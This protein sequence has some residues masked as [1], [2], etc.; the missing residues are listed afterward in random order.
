M[1]DKKKQ[2]AQ[3]T[4]PAMFEGGIPFHQINDYSVA[5]GLAILGHARQS[6]EEALSAFEQLLQL[7]SCLQEVKTSRSE[8]WK[9]IIHF[10]EKYQGFV[11]KIS[12]L[13]L[14]IG[15]GI[16]WGIYQIHEDHPLASEALRTY[17]PQ[18]LA[19][20]NQLYQDRD[21]KEDG[22]I[23]NH[24]PWET[25]HGQ[26]DHWKEML[27]TISPPQ[28]STAAQLTQA[29]ELMG[30]NTPTEHPFCIQ[31]PI[32]HAFLSWSNE[33]LIQIGGHLKEDVLDIIE[34]YELS[35]Y[36]I[37]DQLWNH[38]Q[39]LFCPFNEHRANHLSV[40]VLESAICLFSEFATQDRAEEFY[41]QLE[42][43][44]KKEMQ[45]KVGKNEFHPLHI[46]ERILL[47]EGLSNYGFDELSILLL[48]RLSFILQNIKDEKPAEANSFLIQGFD[49]YLNG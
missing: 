20:H 28:T 39:L 36:C 1:K 45:S 42:K 10:P 32:F 22:L 16:L 47:F 41:P 15:A 3:S 21:P 9:E 2:D 46:A 4:I 37:N 25:L 13:H 7:Q 26:A 27:D 14:P 11:P 48:Q 5:F 49:L 34:K 6:L 38:D 8:Q 30:L 44:L 12:L 33:S 18:L 19:Y 29:Y 31:D 24:H 43:A 23:S 35:I 40:G 17:Y